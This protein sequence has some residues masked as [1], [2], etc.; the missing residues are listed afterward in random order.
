MVTSQELCKLKNIYK[1]L[2]IDK[3]KAKGKCQSVWAAVIE[4]HSY[5]ASTENIHSS[6]CTKGQHQEVNRS[7]IW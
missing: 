7:G 3:D 1:V 2:K 6:L 5:V 4:Y